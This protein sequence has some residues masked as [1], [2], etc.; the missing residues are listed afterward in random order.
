MSQKKRKKRHPQN[1]RSSSAPAMESEFSSDSKRKRLN[2]TSR[3]LL[4]TT[5]ILLAA[6]QLLIQFQVI[7]E[8]LA[9]GLSI[10]ALVLLI[11]ALWVQF[12]D[13]SGGQTSSTPR[14]P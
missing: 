12:Q 9:N 4:L 14:L 8:A 3:N 2:R 13:S 5:L 6:I 10:F 7:S 11:L 1:K